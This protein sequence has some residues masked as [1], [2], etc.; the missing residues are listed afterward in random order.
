M[1]FESSTTHY[2]FTMT[3]S[4]KILMLDDSTAAA[5]IVQELLR[6]KKL[7][8]EFSLAMNK[9]TYL[10]ALDEFHPDVILADNSMPQFSAAEALELSRRRAAHTPFIMV[11]DS[12]SEK[13]DTDIIKLGADDYIF[14]DRLM[15][16]PAAIEAALKQQRIEREKLEAIEKLNLNEENYRNLVDRISDGF[17]ALD[18]NWRFT[19]INKKAQQIF[20]RPSG[21]LAGKHIWTEFPDFINSPF[22][23]AYHKAMETQENS[24]VRKYSIALDKWIEASIYPSLSGISI[25]FRDITEQKKAE[26][27][28]KEKEERYRNLIE[29]TSDGVVIYN[30]DGIILDFNQSS[31]TYL[32]YSKEEFRNLN[33]MDFFPKE[34]LGKRPLSFERLKAGFSTIDYRRLIRKDG[35]KV[36]MEISTTMLADGALMAFGRDITERKKMEAEQKRNHEELAA[37]YK[38]SN[39]LNKAGSVE[40]MFREAM[41]SLQKT[42]HTD[43]TAILLF[44]PDGKMRFKA[45]QNLSDEYRNA[46]EGHSPWD[47][48][49]E[50]AKPIFIHNVEEGSSVEQWRSSFRE[51]GIAAL[52]FVPI[53][54]NGHLLGKIMLYSNTPREFSKRESRLAQ[55]IASHVAFAIER[56]KAEEE[57]RLKETAISKSISGMGMTDLTGKLIYAN[58]ALGK[59]W[60]CADKEELIG[61]MLTDVFE[62]PGVLRTIEALQTKGFANGE[63]IG[64]KM[65]GTLFDVAFAANIILENANPVCMFGS[66]IDITQRKKAEAHIVSEGQRMEQEKLTD[67]I[68]QQQEITRAILQT[69][70]TERNEIGRELHDNI[71]QILSAISIKLDYCLDNYSTSRSVIEECRQNLQLAIKEN[72]NLSH[73]MVMPLF[74]ESSLQRILQLL[75]AN[76]SGIQKMELSTGQMNEEE[77][78]LTIKGTLFRIAQEQLNNIQKHA[79]ADMV[80]V[81]VSND[82]ENVTMLIE[83]DGIGFEPQQTRKGIGIA[84]ILSRVESYNGSAV[85]HSQPGKGCTLTVNIPL[86]ELD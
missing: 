45:W 27:K 69:Q 49:N 79:K 9:E 38:L 75:V 78:P 28:L 51:E 81:H 8:C 18:L 70:E 61:K 24:Y 3:N 17:M 11:T 73:R 65:D 63:D 66:F 12:E 40:E 46:V 58:E 29:R 1:V 72:R 54:Q 43:R 2:E 26:E 77:I 21:Y 5:K 19:Y 50:N 22:Y 31:Y 36:E 4:L 41:N 84:N 39:S 60:G 85:I 68:R 48:H 83:D 52:G 10:Q 53:K 56:K 67:K 16:L 6:K 57:L 34:D 59:M 15:R 7:R 13:S 80:R 35:T 33:I 23:E 44:D 30:L 37:T 47:R 55:N 71:N 82:A 86:T 64:R 25:Y 76:Y 14:K 32:G 42:I 20:K 74:S 62:G